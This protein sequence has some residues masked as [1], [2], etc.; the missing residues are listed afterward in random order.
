MFPFWLGWPGIHKSLKDGRP[1]GYD[2]LR[3]VSAHLS[4]NL[5]SAFKLCHLKWSSYIFVVHDYHA[6]AQLVENKN[7]EITTQFVVANSLISGKHTSES[8]DTWLFWTVKTV[9]PDCLLPVPKENFC[10][11]DSVTFALF[12]ILLKCSLWITGPWFSNKVV[13]YQTDQTYFQ[14]WL[15]L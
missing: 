6:A 9:A 5:S 8:P 2:V 14:M 4:H 1:H 12:P 3:H 15:L 11:K 7:P 10:L 13:V